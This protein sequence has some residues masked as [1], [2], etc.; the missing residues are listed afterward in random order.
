MAE[1]NKVRYGLCNVHV[2]PILK[3]NA[4]GTE[5][6][7]AFRIPGAVDLTIGAE[8]DEN[9]FHADNKVFWN[10]FSN[11]GYSGDLEVALIPE[12]FETE[13]LG[14]VKDKNGAIIESIEAKPKAFA[15]A[16][17]FDGDKHPTRHV[18]YNV[19]TSRPEISGHTNEKGKTIKTD[20]IKITAAARNDGNVKAKVNAGGV[21][22]DTFFTK[23]YE[24]VAE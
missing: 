24:P 12:K 22:Y 3:D 9:P 16:F 21:G 11:N 7:E 19:S 2:F 1:A 23:V 20:K 10:E 8:G 14:L 13:I 5:Y 18:L 15:M 17:E 6:G 4:E